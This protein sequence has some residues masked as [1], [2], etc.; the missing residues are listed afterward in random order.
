MPP[1]PTK[2]E[3]RRR[4]HVRLEAVQDVG[5]KEGQDLREDPEPEHLEP[6]RPGR[7]DRV[8]GTGVDPLDG[9][10]VELREGRGGVR[11]HRQHAGEGAEPDGGN[12]EQRVDQG[13]D[14]PEEVERGAPP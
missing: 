6:R 8:H 10:R 9:L 11:D 4:P 3:H 1:A 2:A 13:V 14:A 5:E 7:P 12:E